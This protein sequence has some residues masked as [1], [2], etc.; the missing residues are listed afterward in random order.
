MSKCKDCVVGLFGVCGVDYC[1]QEREVLTEEAQQTAEQCGH[2]LTEF[3]KIK[4][5]P[6]WEARCVRCER[7]AAINLDPPPNEPD[8]Y[9][10][11]LAVN[12]PEIDDEQIAA[13]S[14]AEM[15]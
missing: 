7:L 8:I 4:D 11:A 15:S 1:R 5:Y 3:V 13:R 10:E 12:C 14:D 9:G 2:T 6:I